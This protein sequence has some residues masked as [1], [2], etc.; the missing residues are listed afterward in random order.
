MLSFSWRR[1]S[2][3]Q[4]RLSNIDYDMRIAETCVHASAISIAASVSIGPNL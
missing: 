1:G 2:I 4:P 3:L